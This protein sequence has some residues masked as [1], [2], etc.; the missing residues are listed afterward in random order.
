MIIRIEN[1]IRKQKL[2][3]QKAQNF[4]I[5]ILKLKECYRVKQIYN[6][7]RDTVLNFYFTKFNNFERNSLLNINFLK[8]VLFSN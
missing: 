5:F 1:K 4:K 2:N 6:K 8:I 7:L 3:V